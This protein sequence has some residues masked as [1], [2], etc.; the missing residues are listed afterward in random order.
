MIPQNFFEI[1]HTVVVIFVLFEQFL[2]KIF[3]T[4][5]LS[6]LPNIMHFF[7]TFSITCA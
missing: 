2:G 5:N 1:L 7:R 4:L 6:V 3:F